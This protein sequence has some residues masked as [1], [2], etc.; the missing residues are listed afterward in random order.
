MAERNWTKELSKIDRQ[1]ESISDEALFPT[2]GGPAKGPAAAARADNLEKQRTTST[3]GVFLRLLLSVALGVGI[4]FWPYD[5]RCGFGLFGYLAAVG[6]VTASGVWS[7]V[8]TWRHRSARGH[9]LSL[10][11]VLWGVILGAMEVLPRVGYAKADALH[12]AT[13][14]CR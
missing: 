5:A 11:L 3:F 9:T 2:K 13:W 12:P 6:V 14:T 4:Y 10:L 1:L 8:W 7:A